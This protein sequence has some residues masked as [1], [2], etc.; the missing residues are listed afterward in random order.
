MSYES[1]HQPTGESCVCYITT[2]YAAAY[3]GTING[4]QF[5]FWCSFYCATLC[6]CSTCC[7]HVSVSLSICLSRAGIV[8][9]WLNIGS[10]KQHHT[11]AHELYFSDAKD[12]GKI[13][14]GHHQGGRQMQVGWVKIGNFQQITHHNSHTQTYTDTKTHTQPFYGSLGFCLG[15]PMWA[16]TRKVKP[17]T[18]NQSEFTGA[19]VS[20]I[21]C[22]S[23]KSAP[24]P[25]QL[26]MAASHHSVIT[27]QMPFLPPSNQQ[28]QS[29]EGTFI[30]IA[31]IPEI[32][33]R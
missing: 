24:W 1:A 22:A 9:K 33:S 13:W 32:D 30:S 8:S 18:L 3:E 10:C 4:N 16:G 31:N 11:I 17:G 19:R 5:S 27:G 2:T 6:Q 21:S 20:G 29:T 23:C 25:R 26:T 14:T 12:L 28:H 15:L 7:C